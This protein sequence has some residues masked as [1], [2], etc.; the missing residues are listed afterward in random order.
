VLLFEGR[1]EADYALDPG[2]Q[3]FLMVQTGPGA[4]T[5]IKVVLDWF[6]QVRRLVPTGRD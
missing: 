5:Q 3:R 2:G 6:E 1:F 4:S